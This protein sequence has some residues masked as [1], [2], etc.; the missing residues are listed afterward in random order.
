MQR[1]SGT[2]SLSPP[3]SLTALPEDEEE[4]QSIAGPAHSFPPVVD[5]RK[6]SS[7]NNSLSPQPGSSQPACSTYSSKYAP[8]PWKGHFEEEQDVSIPDSQNTFHVYTT[9]TEGAVV[10]CLHGAGYSGLSFAL[11]AGM[12]KEKVRVVAMDLRGH[13]L[14]QTD[15]DTDLST[16]TICKDVFDVIYSM[17]GNAAPSIVLVGHSMGGAIA[18]HCAAKR[19]LPTLAGLVV[20]DVVEGTA[21]AS[22]VHMQKVLS[23]RPLHFSSVEKAIEW[24]VR[25]GSLRN[26]DSARISVPST[27]KYNEDKDCYVWLTP[28]E[29]TE[30][31][32]KGW[33]QGLSDLFLSCP[34][35]K[36][37]VLA[38]TDRLDRSLTIGQMQGKFQMIVLRHTGHAIQEDVPDELAR[39]VLNFVSRNFIGPSG[40]KIPTVHRPVA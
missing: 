11:V 22:L 21:L 16:E 15:N 5:N 8:L 7:L 12:M 18:V 19:K 32:W 39:I 4:D 13:G 27:L 38:G 29:K 25:G 37:L 31:H 28:L 26:A 9:G 36:L 20:L 34:V 35:P 2:G 17:Y 24:T 33:Y 6:Q 1:Q 30:D 3:L 40:V 23:N 10:F 14:S